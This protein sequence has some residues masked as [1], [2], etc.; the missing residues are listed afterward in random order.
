MILE[1]SGKS[2]LLI[3]NR[4]K[5]RRL[6]EDSSCEEE[7]NMEKDLTKKRCLADNE[8]YADIINGIVFQGKQLL[9]A[10]D[11]TELDSQVWSINRLFRKRKLQRCFRRT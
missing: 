6:F 7:Q 2:M 9:R 4:D 8:R 3:S 1:Y 5:S 11:L 10:E